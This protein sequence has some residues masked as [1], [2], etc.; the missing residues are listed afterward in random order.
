VGRY[1][2]ETRRVFRP[3]CGYALKTWPHENDFAS[4]ET[5]LSVAP[6]PAIKRPR[7][8]C[9]SVIDETKDYG[10]EAKL[11]RNSDVSTCKR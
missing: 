8:V 9:G 6:L 1:G 3:M 2:R 11:S 4:F 5:P 7:F 10:S